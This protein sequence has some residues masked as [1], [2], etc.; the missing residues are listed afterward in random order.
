MIVLAA[1]AAT[2]PGM[3][4]VM[5]SPDAESAQTETSRGVTVSRFKAI[6]LPTIDSA[7]KMVLAT[8][9]IDPDRLALFGFSNGGGYALFL[10]RS[11]QDIFSRVAALSA[12]GAY[13]G[14]GPQNPTTQFAVSGGIAEL[15]GISQ[16]MVKQTL[17]LAQVLRTEGHLVLTILGLRGH[18]DI[19]TDDAVV[20][21]WFKESWT[22]P[23]ITTQP[24]LPADSDPVLTVETLKKMTDFWT[25]LTKE[26]DSVLSAGRMAHQKPFGLMLGDQPVSVIMTDMVALAKASPSVA[27]D[28]QAAGLT[29]AQEDAY[30]VAILRVGFARASGMVPGIPDPYDTKVGQ[31]LPFT[32]IAPHSVLAQNLAFRAAHSAEFAALAA[33]GMW[34]TQ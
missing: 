3:W 30:R 5:V 7:L 29:A 1:N 11:N 21:A 25:R 32:P 28:L 27:A 34:T 23:D 13:A 20:W 33:T 19:V 10:G 22:H 16:L 2:N 8:E 17:K 31:D 9:A 12:A 15:G 24:R 26:P 14:I 4:D 18:A 6:D